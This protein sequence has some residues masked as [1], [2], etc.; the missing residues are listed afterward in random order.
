[1]V[2][3]PGR[4]SIK[5]LNALSFSPNLMPVDSVVMKSHNDVWTLDAFHN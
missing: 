3:I 1:M 2:F 4:C 5:K